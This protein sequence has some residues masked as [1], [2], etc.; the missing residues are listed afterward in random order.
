MDVCA[1]VTFGV[2]QLLSI[3]TV[4]LQDPNAC[5]IRVE[6]EATGLCN[7]DEHTLSGS[8]GLLQTIPEHES[9]GSVKELSW[10]GSA[11]GGGVG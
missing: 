9:A 7:V 6:S 2:D 10:N 4:Q 11:F 8:E 1:A 5:K 3:E